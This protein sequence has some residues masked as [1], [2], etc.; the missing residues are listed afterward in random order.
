MEHDHFGKLA[1]HEL[2]PGGYHQPV[3]EESKAEYVRLYVQWRLQRGTGA[4]FSAL[5]KGFHELVP[6]SMLTEFNEK[7]LEVRQGQRGG[8][9]EVGGG[10]R[11]EGRG[12]EGWKGSAATQLCDCGVPLTGCSCPQLIVSGIGKIDVEDWRM[13]TRLKNCSEGSSLVQWFWQAVES[14]DDECR[15]R[16]L[17]FVTGSSRVPISGFKG[18]QGGVWL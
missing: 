15:A 6:S 18:L 5:M 8:G 12:G 14:Y 17:Q 7:E 13:N 9:G 10:E 4:Q 1:T 2:K 11:C 16:L 3:T